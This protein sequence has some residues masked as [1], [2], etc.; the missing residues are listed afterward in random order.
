ML[1]A[2]VQVIG[3]VILKNDMC[4]LLGLHSSN[5]CICDSGVFLYDTHIGCFESSCL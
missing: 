2:N 5:K 1:I 4:S 3:N